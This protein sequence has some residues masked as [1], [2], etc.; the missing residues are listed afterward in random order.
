MFYVSSGFANGFSRDLKGKYESSQAKLRSFVSIV[1]SNSCWCKNGERSFPPL[2][3]YLVH[4][5]HAPWC[6][7]QKIN[8]ASYILF[9]IYLSIRFSKI[10]D[11]YDR[12]AHII[13]ETGT[14]N[15]SPKSLYRFHWVYSEDNNN[16][17]RSFQ[18][19]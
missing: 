1:E 11:F 2:V 12:C 10:F 17:L 16:F 19:I 3:V 9:I 4:F 18:K 8:L 15:G 14:S 5:S 13:L 6:C 7:P